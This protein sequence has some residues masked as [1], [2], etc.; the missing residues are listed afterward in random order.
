MK[1]IRSLQ[2]RVSKFVKN[3]GG[4]LPKA[5]VWIF[6]SI[7]IG[8]GVLT[9]VGIIYEF[10]MHGSVNY[11]AVNEFVHEYFSP[12]TAATF[13][14]IGVLLIDRDRDGVPDKWQESEKEDKG[15]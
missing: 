12:S 5:F 14:V 7:F 3:K 8:C 15:E 11:K 4:V 1:L 6:A 9:I 2:N 13:G 10:F